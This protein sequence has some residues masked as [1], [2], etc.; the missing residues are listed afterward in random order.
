MKLTAPVFRLKRDARRLA[1]AQKIPL[2]E[3][4]DR[5]ARQEGLPRWSLLAARE[6]D[7]T[8]AAR[9][10]A[11]LTPG[12]LV[13]V[14]A[15]PRQ[16]KTLF[17]LHLA[18]EAMKDGKRSL[19][20]TLEYNERD[21]TERLDR[22]GI[23]QHLRANLF[24]LDMSDTVSADYV[25]GR[26]ASASPG[27]LIVVDYLQ[28]LDQRRENAALAS[29]V[30]L[31]RHLAMER[32]HVIVIISQ[33]D[34]AFELTGRPMPGLGDVRTPNP[35]DLSLFTKTCFLNAGEISMQMR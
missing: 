1:R 16:G 7:T 5:V 21:V 11:R 2:H 24:T 14:A 29:Q 25:D 26:T 3:A 27:T 32:R 23:S 17:A 20:F 30:R 28:L 13:L 22:L 9:F 34:R 12:D 19:F 6:A 15:R 35:V 4:L 18:A 10:Y 33:I 31:L 8:P